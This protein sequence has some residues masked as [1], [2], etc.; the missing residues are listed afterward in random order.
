VSETLQRRVRQIRGRAERR[1]WAYRQRDLAH[2]VWHR[3]GRALADAAEA[4][5]VSEEDAASLVDR[6]VAA[7]AC[8][9]ALEPPLRLFFVTPAQLAGLRSRRSVPVRLS[10]GLLSA[11]NVALI[12]FALK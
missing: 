11:R 2:G 12:R 8:G 4:W 5:L 6:G 10:A 1:R 9:L 3:V 7:E